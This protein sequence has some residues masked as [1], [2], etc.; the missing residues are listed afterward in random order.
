MIVMLSDWVAAARARLRPPP[1][2]SRRAF[3]AIEFVIVDVETTGWSPQEA[4]ITEIGAVRMSGGQIRAEFSTLVNPGQAIPPDIVALTG[5]S[6]AMVAPAPPAAEALASFL[7]FA[8]GAVLTAH[9]APF[10]VSFLAAAGAGSGLPGPAGPVLDTHVLDTVVLDTV[11]LARRL[12]ATGGLAADDVPNCKL[13]TLAGYFGAPPGPQHRALAD[14]R[15]TATV[16]AGLLR[17]FS[18]RRVR[19]IAGLLAE[20]EYALLTE[21]PRH[22]DPSDGPVRAACTGRLPGPGGLGSLAGPE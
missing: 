20:Q 12:L 7:D 22:S 17:M 4:G 11:A 13:S 15:A 19:T 16:L 6:D 8:Q 14:A 21:V 3:D 5:I 18:A 9:N 2:A 1:W 10:D